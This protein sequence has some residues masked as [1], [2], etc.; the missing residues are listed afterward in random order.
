MC[1][2]ES[3]SGGSESSN[4]EEYKVTTGSISAALL[5]D[6]VAIDRE[7]NP[8]PWGESLF[9]SELSN[10]AARFVGV[11]LDSKLIGYLLAHIVLD[12]AHI[13]SFGIASSHRRLGIGS[14]LL[15]DCLNRMKREGVARVTLEVRAS[16]FSARALYDGFGFHAAGIR[17][18]YYSDNNEDALSLALEF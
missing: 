6:V 15:Q 10:R 7:W 9:S 16:N 3:R 14:F 2:A 18:H 1:A 11:F 12:D 4:K 13:V 8:R 5:S 17:R